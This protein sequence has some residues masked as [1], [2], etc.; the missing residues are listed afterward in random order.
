MIR[1][2][3]L[4]SIEYNGK[5]INT[6]EYIPL[7]K[8]N[9][10]YSGELECYAIAKMFNINLLIVEFNEIPLNKFYSI[11]NFY[12][13]LDKD[14]LANL[15]I[16]EYNRNLKHYS[17]LFF[18]ESAENQDISIDNQ[19]INNNQIKNFNEDIENHNIQITNKEQTI[20]KKE[21]SSLNKILFN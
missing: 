15:C 7:I 14:S 5:I 20:N 21:I 8:K 2:K 3:R 11:Y 1:Y 12:G 4:Y 9:Y 6:D 18:N 19:N 16:I 10:T 17:L 13:V